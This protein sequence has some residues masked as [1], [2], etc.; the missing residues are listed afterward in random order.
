MTTSLPDSKGRCGS[1]WVL[2]WNGTEPAD[3][4]GPGKTHL[5]VAKISARSVEFNE[6]KRRGEE[7]RGCLGLQG[8]VL[9]HRQERSEAWRR[10]SQYCDSPGV[11]QYL[12]DITTSCFCQVRNMTKSQQLCHICFCQLYSCD[13]FMPFNSEWWSSLPFVCMSVCAGVCDVCVH[14]LSSRSHGQPYYSWMCPFS[15]NT[16]TLCLPPRAGHSLLQCHIHLLVKT[17]LYAK[18][19]LLLSQVKKNDGSWLQHLKL[20]PMESVAELEE[21]HRCDM[22]MSQLPQLYVLNFLFEEHS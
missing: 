15:P 2:R 22:L 4:R 12:L 21:D 18:N 8:L 3:P 5:Q 14:L 6:K 9:H 13:V 19:A 11:D 1:H 10:V 17:Q 16:A 20:T 7:R